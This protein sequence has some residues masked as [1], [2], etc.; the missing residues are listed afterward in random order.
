MPKYSP[1]YFILKHNHF[2]PPV[3]YCKV[4]SKCKFCKISGPYR[5]RHTVI[6]ISVINKTVHENRI[7]VG[8]TTCHANGMLT[9]KPAL[10]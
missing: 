8:G 5:L 4:I 1:Q 6:I 10:S 3:N 7:S 9:P 2:F